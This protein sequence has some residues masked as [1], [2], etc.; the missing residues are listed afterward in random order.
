MTESDAVE[1]CERFQQN[2]GQ[3]INKT[4][5]KPNKAGKDLRRL[6]L[7]YNYKEAEKV[8][9][10]LVRGYDP[11]GSVFSRPTIGSMLSR[12]ARITPETEP[13]W[14]K[15][16]N[17]GDII[18]WVP[19]PT[20]SG[21]IDKSGDG[22]VIYFLDDAYGD[23][24]SLYKPEW[25]AICPSDIAPHEL[26]VMN[27]ADSLKLLDGW[28]RGYDRGEFYNGCPIHVLDKKRWPEKENN[29]SQ[30]EEP[31]E[32]RSPLPESDW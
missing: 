22:V 8:L 15:E 20:I 26:R 31:Q 1:L 3:L 14:I 23:D 5:K 32:F 9:D 25:V 10:D 28:L 12:L 4:D 19:K 6:L 21:I 29:E 24:K 27:Y 16:F 13:E 7:Q 11:T 18:Y 30:E 2:F 17:H